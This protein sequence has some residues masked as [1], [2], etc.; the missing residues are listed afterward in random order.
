LV[1]LILSLVIGM[2]ASNRCRKAWMAAAVALFILAV[3]VLGIPRP[4]FSAA[5]SARKLVC[6]LELLSPSYSLTMANPT[7]AMLSQQP[8]LACLGRAGVYRALVFRTDHVLPPARLEG[9]KIGG[10]ARYL[11]STWRALKYGSGEARRRLRARLLQINPI[12]GFRA[13]SVS[14]RWAMQWSC[15]CWHL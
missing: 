6:R 14:V 2:F 15:W 13:G 3:L 9:R 12:S 4:S 8:S 5:E 7:A 10:K 1:T 11:Y